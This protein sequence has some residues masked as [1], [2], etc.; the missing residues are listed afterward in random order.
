MRVLVT[1]GAGFIG[2]HLAEHLLEKGHLVDVLDNLSTGCL[3]NVR[4]LLEHPSFRLE[5]DTV[6]NSSL[7]SRMMEGCDAV[8]HL[9]AAVGVQL[10]V[11]DAVGTIET[12]VKGTEAVLELAERDRKRVLLASTSEVYGKSSKIPFSEN[13][14]LVLGPSNRAR[15]SYACSKAIDEFLGLAYWA[16][17]QVPVTIVRLFN[18]VGPRQLGR[19]GMVLPNLVRQALANE[20]LTVFGDGTQTRCFCH[21]SDAV[22]AL[23]GLLL[24]ESTTGEVYNVGS[25]EEVTIRE[26]AGRVIEATH[27]A[28]PISLVPY[29]EAYAPGFEDMRRRVP[30]LRKLREAIGFS[31]AYDLDGIVRSVVAYHTRAAGKLPG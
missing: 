10:I 3:E 15:W 1:G 20:P 12:N 26:L 30:D 7:L 11:S 9:A 6:L 14:D 22:G 28:S 8:I 17:R 29:E 13:D 4:P 16:E 18:T 25:D 21:V 31:P 19:Y 5:V 23:T 24:N 27:S 2:S